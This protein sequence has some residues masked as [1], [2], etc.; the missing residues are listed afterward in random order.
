MVAVGEAVIG[1]GLLERGLGTKGTGGGAGTVNV[2][3]FP[4]FDG[5]L[6]LLRVGEGGGRTG[7]VGA[8][9]VDGSRGR[10]ETG[11]RIV[12]EVWFAP[13][14][15]D[16]FA[17]PAEARL[18]PLTEGTPSELA[19]LRVSLPSKVDSKLPLLKAFHSH[20]SPR[21][22]PLNV[23]ALQPPPTPSTASFGSSCSLKSNQLPYTHLR[24]Q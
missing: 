8:L 19:M 20:S 23:L 2:E 4:A 15:N 12:E 16:F 11:E 24:S 10:V 3:G 21:P 1:A 13:L 9:D 18:F 14:E 7:D 6:V 17:L 22:R 5:A